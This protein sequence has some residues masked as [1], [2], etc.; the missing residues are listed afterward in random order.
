MEFAL[1]SCSKASFKTGK[2]IST[3]NITDDT[4]RE[5]LH[6]RR[7]ILVDQGVKESVGMKNDKMKKKRR[8]K[9]CRRAKLI[10]RNE[11]K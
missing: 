1:Q 8:N 6:G 2:L 5:E 3:G 9:H 7:K 10:K 4:K 11:I